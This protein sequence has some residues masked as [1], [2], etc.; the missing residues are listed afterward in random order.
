MS[1]W[2]NEKER[3]NQ[4]ERERKGERERGRGRMIEWVKQG[5]AGEKMGF[6]EFSMV[7]R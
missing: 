2:A 3:E 5:W 6:E 7:G 4:R 1:G